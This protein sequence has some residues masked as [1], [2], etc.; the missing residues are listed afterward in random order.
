MPAKAKLTI[1]LKADEK[2]VAEVENPVLWQRV[3][4]VINAA[5]DTASAVDQMETTDDLPLT[6]SNN[7]RSTDIADDD[8]V[9]RFA[10]SIGAPIDAV[11][12]ALAPSMKPPYLHLDR[13][14]WAAM[15]KN[16]PLRGPRSISPTGLAGTLLV[17]WFE[18]AK[19]DKKP[20]QALV[21]EVLKTANAIDKNPSRSIRNTKW[22]QSRTAGSFII[23]PAEIEKANEVVRA[24]CTKTWPK[25]DD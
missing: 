22:L 17:R 9:G 18:E 23:N 12:G 13:H 15:K 16:I 5:G 2:V 10:K 11:K 1:V 6:G 21:A 3:L 24:F 7:A 14:C 8:A 20:T 25:A 4:G 19:I